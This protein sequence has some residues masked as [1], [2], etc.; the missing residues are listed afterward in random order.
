VELPLSQPQVCPFEAKHKR[1]DHG[2]LSFALPHEDF[3]TSFKVLKRSFD[4]PTDRVDVV[5]FHRNLLQWHKNVQQ[6]ISPFSSEGGETTGE[7]R[8]HKMR[9]EQDII[10][11]KALKLQVRA[12]TSRRRARERRHHRSKDQVQIR[13]LHAT[14][15]VAY[16]EA[17]IATADSRVT[18]ATQVGLK[19]LSLDHLQEAILRHVQISPNWAYLL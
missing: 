8:L 1:Y 9:E 2:V 7:S 13:R 4:I 15:A 14:L 19:A 11:G 17:L 18:V 6:R 3:I 5:F 16:S 10:R 12:Q